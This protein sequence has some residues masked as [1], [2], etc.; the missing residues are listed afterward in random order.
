MAWPQSVD[1]L[2]KSLDYDKAD[3]A[4]YRWWP[5]GKSR[6][7]MVDTRLNA[8]RPS[9]AATGVRTDI[10]ALCLRQGWE[11]AAV[12]EDLAAQADENRLGE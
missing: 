1:F 4:A 7:V 11:P 10:I 3:H 6:P 5:L 2:L 8:R 12:A 9:T